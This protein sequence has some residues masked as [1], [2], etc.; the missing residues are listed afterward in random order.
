MKFGD[1]KQISKETDVLAYAIYRISALLAKKI[2]KKEFLLQSHKRE[3]EGVPGDKPKNPPF[4][5][6]LRDE[7]KA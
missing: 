5:R 2:S 4:L 3:R 6:V 1:K 7:D